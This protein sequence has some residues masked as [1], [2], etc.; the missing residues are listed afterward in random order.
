M[1]YSSDYFLGLVDR[2]IDTHHLLKNPFYQAWTHGKLSLECLRQYAVEYYQHIKAF[3]TYLSALHAHMDGAK[4]MPARLHILQN[5]I[6]EEAGSP[7]HLDLWR[8]FALELGALEAE[9]DDPHPSS[10]IHNVISTFKKFC[11]EG[12]IAVGI[13]V[14]YAY[15]S[16]I[17]AVSISKIEGLRTHYGLKEPASWQYFTVHIAA[18]TEHAA[19]ERRLLNDYL[20]AD[21]AQDV[22]GAVQCVLDALN[23]FL[24]S[25][26]ERFEVAA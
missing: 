14:L 4:D 11:R 8:S 15:E 25:L 6:E 21:N 9:L 13:A 10:A 2:Q 26:H 23:N 7:N 20:T 12:S 24:I 18:D 16:Q 5:L 22:Q 1:P 17:P 19:I 3:P